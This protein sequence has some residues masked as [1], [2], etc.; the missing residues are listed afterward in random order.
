MLKKLDV[1]LESYQ[2]IDGKK[3]FSMMRLFDHLSTLLNLSDL[4]LNF[5]SSTLTN[6]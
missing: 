1:D 4:K 3:E 2:N 5:E 6:Y